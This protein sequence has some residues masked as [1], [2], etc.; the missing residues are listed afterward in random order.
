MYRWRRLK[1]VVFDV[2]GTLYRSDSY[3]KHLRKTMVEVL[4]HLLG[5]GFDEAYRR[6]REVKARVR[7]F[8]LS[9]EVL[10]IDRR[11]FYNLVADRV[12]ACKYIPRRPELKTMLR[13]LHALGLKVG[14]HTNSGRRLAEKVLECLGLGLKDFDVCVTSED[15]APKPLE[16]GYLLFLSRLGLNPDEVLYVGDRWSVEVEPAKK[17]G[18][19]TALVASRPRG[20]PDLY[21]R[22]VVELPD[23]LRSLLGR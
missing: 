18:M 23:I 21:L 17:L 4:A 1:A 10:G 9:V 19:L 12:E 6:L 13:E 7:T 20:E 14:C 8:S 3:V 16:G 15:A 11:T 22:D 5:V 2:D